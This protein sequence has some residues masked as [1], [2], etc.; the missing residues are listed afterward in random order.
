MFYL[1]FNLKQGGITMELNGC[2]FDLKI[3]RTQESIEFL[4]QRIDSLSPGARAMYLNERAN[5]LKLLLGN[6]KL[7]SKE[8]VDYDFVN[9]I[10]N[11]IQ[12]MEKF[13]KE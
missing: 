13:K 3:T 12:D 10:D 11:I 4:Q 2:V 8:L 7:F 9:L 6:K 5:D 1:Q